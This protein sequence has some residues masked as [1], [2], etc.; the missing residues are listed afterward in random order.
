MAL[1]CIDRKTSGT[2]V[3]DFDNPAEAEFAIAVHDQKAYV[4]VDG[5]PTLYTLSV[6]QTTNGYIGNSVLSGTNRDYGTR[7]EATEMLLWIMNEKASAGIT[8]EFGD[9]GCCF[10][11]LPCL[12]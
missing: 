12:T 2:G 9:E 4:L 3:Y 10:Q 11:V 1:I 5:V 8:M 6:D 7:C